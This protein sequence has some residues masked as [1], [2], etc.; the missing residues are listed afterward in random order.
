MELSDQIGRR[1]EWKAPPERIISCVPSLSEL[2]C[3]LGFSRRIKGCTKF[4]IYP[5][6]LRKSCTVVGG[7]KNLRLEA[8]RDLKPDL[9]LVNKEENVKEQ[10]DELMEE[11]P[12]YVSDVKNVESGIRLIKDV[13]KLLNVIP[14]GEELSRKIDLGFKKLD[15]AL[16]GKHPGKVV[17]FIWRNPWM[18][19]GGDTYIS[20]VLRRAGYE[21]VFREKNRYPETELEELK[22][23]AVD[24]IFL[25]SEPYPFSDKDKKFMQEIFPEV[26]IRLVDG[27]M[28]SWYGSRMEKAAAYLAAL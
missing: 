11:Y 9:I 1:V 10:V 15:A 8:I 24:E 20:D 12:V 26:K 27:S 28:F 23:M 25:S 3:D 7:T 4:C 22:T 13:S 2:V 21:N 17:Y 19:I 5:E 16:H 18:T 6:N 14:K